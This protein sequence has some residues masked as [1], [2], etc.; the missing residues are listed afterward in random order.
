M[1]NQARS[2]LKRLSDT[3]LVP[4]ETSQDIR[5]RKVVDAHGDD[6]GDVQDLW[7]D[8]HEK[9]V[10]LLEVSAG[11]FLGFGKTRFLIPVDAIT[12]VDKWTV[13]ITQ[14]RDHVASSPGYDP[15]LVNDGYLTEVYK[16]YGMSPYWTDGYVYPGFPFYP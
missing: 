12:R 1:A 3:T 6:V 11:G 2:A 15:K 9:H 7:I 13:H 16:H 8:E 4:A 10:R 5:G 14:A